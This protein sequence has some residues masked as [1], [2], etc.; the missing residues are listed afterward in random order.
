MKQIN[1]PARP[2]LFFSSQRLERKKVYEMET[3]TC[4]RKGY[5][6]QSAYSEMQKGGFEMR[7]FIK[8]QSQI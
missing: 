2:L 6:I 1:C 4:L 3:D 8:V 7:I 5:E